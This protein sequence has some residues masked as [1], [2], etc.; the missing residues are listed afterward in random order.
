MEGDC[1]YGW[2]GD[3]FCEM[4]GFVCFVIVEYVLCLW[5]KSFVDGCGGMGY[6][7]W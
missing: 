3:S 1:I 6:V 4:L 2:G 5:C 7:Y